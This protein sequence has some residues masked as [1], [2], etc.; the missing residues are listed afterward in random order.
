MASF[1]GG[2]G[3]PDKAVDFAQAI[4]VRD[5]IDAAHLLDCGRVGSMRPPM[6]R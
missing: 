1:A 4:A 3:G 5:R 6:V 2:R